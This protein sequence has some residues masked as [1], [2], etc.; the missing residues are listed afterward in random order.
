MKHNSNEKYLITITGPSGAGKTTLVRNLL[1]YKVGISMGEIISDTTRPM[2][3]GET[4]GVDYNFLSD[5]D[6]QSLTMVEKAVYDNYCYGISKK[7]IEKKL[8]K[9]NV[10]FAVVSIEG[11]ICLKDYIHKH[12][13]EVICLSIFINTPASVLIDRLVKRGDGS[14][15][16]I[17]RI[18]HIKEK[19]EYENKEF[20]DY[21]FTPQ[22]YALYSPFIMTK[23]FWDFLR[24]IIFHLEEVI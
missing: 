21:I 5:A 17:K 14:D 9:N 3:T 6:F 7:E 1:K 18:K 24:P 19:L 16:I 15:R 11:V 20:C 12:H 13:P 8:S 2:R 10:T 23:D 4:D 22:D